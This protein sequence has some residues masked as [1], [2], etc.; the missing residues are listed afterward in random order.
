MVA[1]ALKKRENILGWPGKRF[2]S[3]SVQWKQIIG[4][5]MYY[6]LRMFWVLAEDILRNGGKIMDGR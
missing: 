6:V 3:E 4:L 1:K 5:N 2:Q